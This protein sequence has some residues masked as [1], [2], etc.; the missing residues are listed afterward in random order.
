MI[1]TIAP[2]SDLIFGS[3]SRSICSMDPLKKA[4]I[5]ASILG[6]VPSVTSIFLSGSR[7]TNKDNS[8]SDIDFFI[9]VKPGR[10]W[11]ARFFVFLLLKSTGQLAKPKKHKMKICPNHFITADALSIR[12]KDGYAAHMFSQNCPLYDPQ[13]IYSLFKEQNTWVA[14]FGEHFPPTTPS[15]FTLRKSRK[16]CMESLLKRIQRRKILKNTDY[17]TR[18]HC[19]ILKDYELRFHPVPK[20]QFYSPEA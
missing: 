15:S 5:W 18:D 1:T 4:R 20:N 10:I 13:N 7:A 12:E 8:D 14:L 2:C 19:I 6:V 11:T 17:Q 16:S 9:I 3:Y